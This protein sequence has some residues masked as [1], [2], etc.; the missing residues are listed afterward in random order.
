MQTYIVGVLGA[1]AV[2]TAIAAADIGLEFRAVSPVYSVGDTVEFGLYAVAD[3]SVGQTLSA[4]EAIFEWDPAFLSLVGLDGA[5]GASFLLADFM[6]VGSG[7]LNEAN[8]P[9]DGDGL[10]IGLASLGSPILAT[11]SG[12]LLTTFQFEALAETPATPLDLLPQAGSP[13][14]STIVFDGAVPNTDVTG[15]LA[16]DTVRIVPAPGLAF[17]AMLMPLLARR[18]R[19]PHRP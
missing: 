4:L 15:A 10:F 13:L 6:M 19:L 7:G 14:R 11:P 5:G 17:G 12:T 8:P 16:G 3:S 2:T 9:A 18:R 1:V